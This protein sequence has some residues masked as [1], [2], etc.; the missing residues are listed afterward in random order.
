[1]KTTGTMITAILL[2]VSSFGQ[3]E[4]YVQAMLT[5]IARI[6]HAS[7]Q[8]VI[9]DCVNQF[10]RIANAEQTLWLPYYYGAYGLIILS[11]N[12]ADK[13]KKD[14]VLERAQEILDQALVLNPDESE[15]HALQ[16]FLY[17]SWVTVDPMGRGMEYMEKMGKALEK[18]KALNPDNPRTLF[19]EAINI[20]NFPPSMGGGPDAARPIFEEADA[21]FRAFR[22]DDPLWPHW[23]EDANRAELEKLQ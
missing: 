15:L 11:F 23:G 3:D 20:L 7:D 16:A 2:S 4:K 22:N 5:T 10:E 12:E 19:L 18:A 21:K 6:E 8:E 17:P 1:M 9:L 14:Q 13:I